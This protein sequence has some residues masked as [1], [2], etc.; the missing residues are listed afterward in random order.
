MYLVVLELPNKKSL[1]FCRR[2]SRNGQPE[3]SRSE[4][5]GEQKLPEINKSHLKLY[6]DLK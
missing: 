5:K 3:N 4:L 2:S 1:I 6:K